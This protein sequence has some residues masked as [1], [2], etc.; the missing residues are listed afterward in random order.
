MDEKKK[1]P[2]I[3][4]KIRGWSESCVDERTAR[5]EKCVCGGR[6]TGRGCME[7]QV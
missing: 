2:E 1:N 6:R 4:S 3:E 7:W 5:G